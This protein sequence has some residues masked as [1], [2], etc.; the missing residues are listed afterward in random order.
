MTDRQRMA[1]RRAS[2]LVLAEDNQIDVASPF[3]DAPNDVAGRFRPTCVNQALYSLFAEDVAAA[4]ASK[5]N[6][7][8]TSAVTSGTRL[9]LYGG[10]TSAGGVSAARLA[11]H[12]CVSLDRRGIEPF[13]APPGSR[14][15]ALISHDT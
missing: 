6:L 8:E 14:L 12:P 3:A 15:H 1:L 2:C 4:P 7:A 5:A 13:G 11:A 9:G 10:G